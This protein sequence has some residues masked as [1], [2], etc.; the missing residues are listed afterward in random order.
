M[1][2]LLAQEV[3][4][5]GGRHVKQSVAGVNC[6]GSRETAY[7][8]CLWSRTANRVLLSLGSFP[9]ETPEALYAGIQS[10]DWQQHLGPE[11]TLAVD[12]N[13]SQSQ[14]NHSRFASLKVKDAIV[15]QFRDGC[16]VRPSVDVEQPL[17]RINVYIFRDEARL[18]LDLSGDSLHRRGYRD[19]A[20]IAPLKENLAAAILLKGGWPEI[21][22]A[23]G[24][25]VDPMCGSGTLPIEAAL[26]A[27]DVA[28]GLSR[29]YF[30]FL[31]WRGHD[32]EAWYR[33]LADAEARQVAG[34]QKLPP[35]FG[36][37]ADNR[38]VRTA[39]GNVEKAGLHGLVHI[40][41]REVRDLVSVARMQENPGLVAV[42]P[43]YGERIGKDSELPQLYYDLGQ[44]LKG[45]FNH[46]QATLLTGNPPLAR[47]LGIKSS[48]TYTLYNGAIECKLLNYKLIEK[49]YLDVASPY[50]HNRTRDLSP[51]TPAQ[52][53]SGADMLANRLKKN[54]KNIGRWAKQKNVDCYRLYDADLPEYAFAL[55]LYQGEQLWANMQEYDA[56]VTV[57]P[58]KADARLCDAL[59][60]IPEVLGIDQENLF[61]KIRQRKKGASQ[62]EKHGG[63]GAFH[64]MRDG[65][66]RCWVNF[67]DYLDTGLFLDHRNTRQMIEEMSRGKRFLN[68]FAY[69]GVASVHA[70]AGGAL[71]VVTVDMSRT[72]LDWAK[73]NFRLND[74]PLENH[75]FVQA[76]CLN[77]LEAA[78][79]GPQE[80]RAFD[81]IFLDPPTF[82]TSKRMA[83]TWEVQRDHV[84]LIRQAMG[85]LSSGGVLIFSTN[86][87]K[88][89]LDRKALDDLLI[90]D[91]SASS[92][93]KDFSRNPRIHYCW[94]L[95]HSGT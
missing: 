69:T 18:S 94:T 57:D 71:D 3:R 46:W 68:L 61:L 44:A 85:L 95:R 34:L 21:A 51:A 32:E 23:G 55:D 38:A 35:I 54:L 8:I 36:F 56:P 76:D 70:A 31:G 74:I 13:V 41:K 40:E 58:A 63:E 25:L 87:R 5:C 29:D 80:D 88:F 37:D 65:D 16:G 89:K 15:D 81:I 43:P 10:I 42:N 27:G 91:I 39:L 83:N 86:F 84:N 7:R 28:P 93:P 17:L 79:K 19:R 92:L 50:P 47:Y 75:R 1:E 53:T 12:S 6:I 82:S 20:T 22:A 60:V 52:R 59:G 11:D 77:W 45:T 9:A 49:Y 73:K 24:T 72:Y 67:E 14:I 30:G 90:E 78:G 62:Y 2:G 4:A 66:V 33:L 64:V 48:H 26:M